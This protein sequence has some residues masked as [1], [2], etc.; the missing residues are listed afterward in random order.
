MGWRRFRL[1][2]PLWA[3]VAGA[4]LPP[5]AEAVHLFP[6]VAGDPAGDCA[7]KLSA[8][9]GRPGGEVGV[10]YF[11]FDDH[12]SGFLGADGYG[13]VVSLAFPATTTIKVGESVT[14]R[15]E[16]PYCH[17]IQSGSVPA[18]AK[19]FSTD[20]GAGSATGLAKGE[21]SLVRPDGA[22]NSFTVTFTVPGTYEYACVHH[23]SVGMVG[24]V[25]VTG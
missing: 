24:T 18:G 10:G 1:L 12:P 5:A 17:S 9:Q 20:G 11:S 2:L 4:V 6:L 16:V 15:W 19:P 7:P 25:T 3:V 21:D 23:K 22:N 14:W 13:P 8:D